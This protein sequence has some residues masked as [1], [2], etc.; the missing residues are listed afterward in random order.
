[1]T[2]LSPGFLYLDVFVIIFS[3][4]QRRVLAAQPLL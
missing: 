1:M 3:L 2:D 4:V